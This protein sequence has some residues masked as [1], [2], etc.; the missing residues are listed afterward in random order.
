MRSPVI[1]E[2]IDLNRKMSEIIAGSS[3]PVDRNGQ[4]FV[5]DILSERIGARQPGIDNFF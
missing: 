1:L 3:A 2:I 4:R 5:I